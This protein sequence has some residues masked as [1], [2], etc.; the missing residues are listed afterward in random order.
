MR[1]VTCGG[2]FDRQTGHYL[3]NIVVFGTHVGRRRPA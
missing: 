3:G 1:L 2:A